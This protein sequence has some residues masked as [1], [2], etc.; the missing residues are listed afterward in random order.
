MIPQEV[1][2]K[3]VFP[4]ETFSKIFSKE[5]ECTVHYTAKGK[6]E[7]RQKQR[8]EDCNVLLICDIHNFEKHPI[9]YLKTPW[10][11]E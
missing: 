2:P 4:I 11:H 10:F 3:E 6:Y 5:E 7:I 8:V 1:F 9:V